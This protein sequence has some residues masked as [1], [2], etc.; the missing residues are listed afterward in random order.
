MEHRTD[1]D[2]DF[3]VTLYNGASAIAGMDIDGGLMPR[4]Y[5]RWMAWLKQGFITALYVMSKTTQHSDWTNIVVEVVE[6]FQMMALVLPSQS[7][8]PFDLDPSIEL[9]AQFVSLFTLTED[10]IGLV[11]GESAIFFCLAVIIASLVNGIY[12]G[13]AW[14]T[15]K[16]KH[17]WSIVS[18]RTIA[19]ALV[20]YLYIPVLMTLVS[21]LDCIVKPTTL[22]P[23]ACGVLSVVTVIAGVAYIS[24][25]LFVAAT[26]FDADPAADS[27]VTRPHAQLDQLRLAI[28]TA[29]VLLSDV[30]WHKSWASQAEVKWFWV[31]FTLLCTVP[32]TYLSIEYQPFYRPHANEV[33]AVLSALTAWCV[34]AGTGARLIVPESTSVTVLFFV[35]FVLLIP[36]TLMLVRLRRLAL[37]QVSIERCRNVFEVELCCRPKDARNPTQEELDAIPLKFAAAHE[38]F[39]RSAFLYMFQSVFLLSIRHSPLLARRALLQAE[40]CH[41]S[42]SQAFYIFKQKHRL[43]ENVESTPGASKGIVA[44]ASMQKYMQDACSCDMQSCKTLV[45]FW[46]ELDRPEPDMAKLIP[47]A[48]ELAAVTKKAQESYQQ[49]LKHSPNNTKVLDLFGGFQITV[50]NDADSADRTYRKAERAVNMQRR[51][52]DEF[53]ESTPTVIIAA[54]DDPDQG[55]HQGTVLD[56]NEQAAT[57]FGRALIGSDQSEL[58]L[59]PLSIVLPSACDRYL[60]EGSEHLF[61]RPIQ[62]FV[63]DTRRD[64]VSVTVTLRPFSQDGLMFV[65]YASIR[66]ARTTRHLILADPVTGVVSAMTTGAGVLMRIDDKNEAITTDDLIQNYSDE[67]DVFVKPG[68]HPTSMNTREAL[69]DP[70]AI[71]VHVEELTLGDVTFD[72]IDI[73]VSKPSTSAI[74]DD[75]LIGTSTRLQ[76]VPNDRRA[77]V[78]NASPKSTISSPA[79]SPGVQDTTD[80]GALINPSRAGSR[81]QSMQVDLKSGGRMAIAGPSMPR[82]TCSSVRSA[83]RASSAHRRSLTSSSPSGKMGSQQSESPSISELASAPSPQ[84]QRRKSAS[85]MTLKNVPSL[86]D[87]QTHRTGTVCS[88]PSPQPMVFSAPARNAKESRGMAQVSSAPGSSSD[89]S[90]ASSDVSAVSKN[91]SRASS[92]HG[93]RSSRRSTSSLASM[94]SRFTRRYDMKAVTSAPCDE[95]TSACALQMRRTLLSSQSRG[96][97]PSLKVFRNVLCISDIIVVIVAVVFTSVHVMNVNKFLAMQ[98]VA[99]GAVNRPHDVLQIAFCVHYLMMLRKGVQLSPILSETAIRSDLYRASSSLGNADAAIFSDLST[100]SDDLVSKYEQPTVALTYLVQTRNATYGTLTRMCGTNDAASAFSTAAA[101]AAAMPLS[102]FTSGNDIVFFILAN[103]VDTLPSSLFST[104]VSTSAIL[105]TESQARLT[106][107]DALGVGIA[108]MT[109]ML[110]SASVATVTPIL[111]RIESSKRETLGFLTD[112]P[113]ASIA[114]IRDG[115]IDRLEVVHGCTELS[116]RE[117]REGARQSANSRKKS[118]VGKSG[119]LPKRI[120][121]RNW[122]LLARIATIVV[123]ALVYCSVI[124]AEISTAVAVAQRLPSHGMLAGQRRYSA[125]KV[126]LLL[127]LEATAMSIQT[128]AGAFDISGQVQ[129]SLSLFE[130]SEDTLIYGNPSSNV[131]GVLTG[132]GSHSTAD[133][134]AQFDLMMQDACPWFNDGYNLTERDCRLFQNGLLAHGLH[135]AHRDFVQVVVGLI[136]TVGARIDNA[137]LAPAPASSGAW[138]RMT[139][140]QL[141]STAS[142]G[143]L[144]DLM[145]LWYLHL[146]HLEMASQNLYLSVGGT[147]LR[148]LLTVEAVS[149]IVFIV[150][151][152]IQYRFVVCPLVAH[153]DSERQRTRMLLMLVPDDRLAALSREEDALARF[154][155]L[156]H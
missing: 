135:R 3:E 15:G 58:L 138:T 71:D 153:L 37:D 116:L 114:A 63:R 156:Y 55:V 27:P 143:A 26:F 53:D 90:D 136:S 60:D 31:I 150:L 97:E 134:N 141:S 147:I 131:P 119:G 46:N 144:G 33:G 88:V 4:W 83:L 121:G 50:L 17:L 133:V 64:M 154:E 7:S 1:N 112:L 101:Q 8:M 47:I 84:H 103:S 104:L 6:A 86:S 38:R 13:Y 40:L 54:C 24:V 120:R 110:L 42:M 2:D 52:A 21:G 117:A 107:F 77:T 109:L 85:V 11:G 139:P 72:V 132:T 49:L 129:S 44:F 102:E 43:R 45:A 125:M 148:S 111:Q 96:M 68:W 70:G 155:R 81:R 118:S 32:P 151:V 23:A 48:D 29:L 14:Q 59:P 80:P 9:W 140:E 5:Y 108:V 79:R 145:N 99:A 126:A 123:I 105:A 130:S 124:G 87:L 89:D 98:S 35:G 51:A 73:V 137:V 146:D 152:A 100:F 18:L 65:I 67:R 122:A 95:A 10:L 22:S 34:C 36:I 56:V 115:I 69:D 113:S 57:L 127:H 93:P 39:P 41:P 128:G 16:F 92:A 66:P 106:S 91:S 142:N 19:G 61:N 30:I 94:S 62:A 28:K 82:E 74:D 25:S 75:V 12:V 78:A 76:A 149:L 20:T